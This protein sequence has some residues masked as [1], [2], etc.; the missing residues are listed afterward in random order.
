SKTT[1]RG[2]VTQKTQ[3]ASTGTSP[4]TKYAYYETGQL[5]TMTEP[6]GIT[7]CN[8]IGTLVP[9][10]QY[11]YADSYAAG[12]NTC[13]SANGP[14]GNTNAL[15]TKVIYPPTNGVVHSECFSYDYTSGQLTGSKDE[16]GQLTTYIYS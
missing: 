9:A 16:N 14:A 15:L 3:W 11:V 10:T 5:F 12:S 8:D 13:T 4:V 7:I 6:C 1:P 2:N